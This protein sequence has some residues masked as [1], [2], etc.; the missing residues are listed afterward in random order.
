MKLRRGEK[1][2][3]KV[4]SFGLCLLLLAVSVFGAAAEGADYVE[5]EWNYVDESM[6]VNGGIPGDAEGVLARI[7]RTGVLKVAVNPD[8]TPRVFIDPSKTGTDRYVGADMVLARRIA[9]RMGVRLEV[10]PLESTQILLAVSEDHSDLTI[11]GVTFTPG[12]AITYTLSKGYYFPEDVP[13]TGIMI[14]KEDLENITSLDDLGGKVLVVQSNSL[15]ETIGASRVLNYLEYRR[16]A[17][18]QTVYEI[19]QQGKADAAIVDIQSAEDYISRN[20]GCG[21]CLVEGVSFTPDQQFL[22]DRVAAKKGE[23]QL[24]YFVNG[25]IDE[26]LADGSYESWMEEARQRA[27][28]LGL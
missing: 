26:V 17:S 16:A 7:K 2:M 25:V 28:E 6:N 3:K 24:M 20:P 23:A 1:P 19:L 18:V 9:E 11:S 10:I 4:L 8:L 27:E 5:N 12:R 21:L 13:A 22:G 14:R 15:Q